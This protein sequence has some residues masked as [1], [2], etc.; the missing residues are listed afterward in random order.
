MRLAKAIFGIGL[1]LCLLASS[2]GATYSHLYVFGDSLSDTG[3]LR[4]LV[5]AATS[6]T[7]DPLPPPPTST[8]ISRTVQWPWNIWQR[9][10]A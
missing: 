9:N 1:A 8:A 6:G 4:N 5:L 3:N 7:T 10:W 2:A